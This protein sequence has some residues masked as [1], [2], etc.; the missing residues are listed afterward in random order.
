MSK[1]FD[2]YNYFDGGRALDFALN[3][4][5]IADLFIDA[6]VNRT[7]R[8]LYDRRRFFARQIELAFVSIEHDN[9]HAQLLPFSEA[10]KKLESEEVSL[11]EISTG[12]YYI[13]LT[14]PFARY[15]KPLQ[16]AINSIRYQNLINLRKSMQRELDVSKEQDISNSIMEELGIY[17]RIKALFLL[18]TSARDYS[19]LQSNDN[20]SLTAVKI[21]SNIPVLP[22]NMSA[23]QRV[24]F[25]LATLL[26]SFLEQ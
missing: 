7:I 13:G 1:Y 5:D 4:L 19:D 3:D 10:K 18:L 26:A 25:A 20:Y 21:N 6:T 12:I 11:R 22:A 2:K 8:G 16:R 17:D 24:C 9:I 15:S 23:G 14:K